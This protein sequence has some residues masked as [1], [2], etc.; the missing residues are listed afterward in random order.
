MSKYKNIPRINISDRVW[1]DN[2]IT[3]SPTWCAVD[4]RDGNQAL[5]NPMTPQQKKEYFNLLCEI[6]FKEIE[7]GFP[8]AS[9]DD[10][11]FCRDLIEQDMIPDDVVISVLTQARPHLI[12][13]TVDVLKGVKKA[14][15]H[16]YIATSTLHMK[17]VFKKTE[18][19]TIETIR[20]AVKQIKD[21]SIAKLSESDIG[22][23]FSPEEFTDTDIDF[24]VEICDEVVEQWNPKKDEKVILNLPATVERRPPTHYADMIELFNKKQAHRDNTIISIHSHNDMGCAV[25]SSEMAVM[26]GASRVEGTLFGHGERTGNVDLVT[27]ICNLQ[28]MGV[29]TAIDFSNLDKISEVVSRITD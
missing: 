21:E 20:D 14:I 8:S 19:D 1:P 13:K 4:L 10:F 7:V 12:S 27:M 29:S 2:E 28:Y 9:E 6:G 15:I 5:P 25:A 23:E 11:Q 18:K 16:V 26:A 17:Y 3:E 24:A 22:L